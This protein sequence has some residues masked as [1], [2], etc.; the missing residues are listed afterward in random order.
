MVHRNP[1]T[2]RDD[3][4]DADTN[5]LLYAP[6]V[7]LE[8]PES[9]VKKN[10]KRELWRQGLL[11]VFYIASWYF[12][13][14]LLSLYNKWMFSPQHLNFHYPLFITSFHMIMQ[15]GMAAAVLYFIPRF[16]PP[17][18]SL[19]GY[20]DYVK[21]IGPCG[22]ATGLDIGL[23]NASLK[24]ISLA[25]YT[26]VKSSSL[27]WVLLFAFIFRLEKPRASLIGVIALITVGVVL[28]VVKETNFV[29]I[30][31]LL[32]LTASAL[33][34]FR[35]SLTQILLKKNPATS[36]PFS[37]I[38]FLAPVM[39]VTLIVSAVITEGISGFFTK[40][41]EIWHEKG[42]LTIGILLLPGFLAFLMTVAEF[43]LIQCTSVVTLSVAG[44]F[45]EMLTILVGHVVFRDSQFSALNISGL[46]V[47]ILGIA[48][49]NYLKIR[50]M[51][52]E[53]T[54]AERDKLRP[55]DEEHA[56]T[57]RR[58]VQEDDDDVVFGFGS[59]D[60]DSDEDHQQ[61]GR[62]SQGS[63]ASQEET[64]LLRST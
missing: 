19:F 11:N 53:A 52:K 33:G 12:F 5:G 26:M 23:S 13:S 39:F 47:T 21:K 64:R 1:S 49:Y 60:E 48:L 37:T 63:H 16:R 27:G 55:N 38:L 40:M 15:F 17:R 7:I 41:G 62:Q 14:L 56:D 61:I 25:F 42:I 45:K 43:S 3:D 58:K 50:R 6:E 2:D 20:G 30:G 32:V 10:V 54:Q 44:I 35:W 24:T 31:F 4:N 29:L 8:I 51:K 59:E 36:N 28:M 22:M 57:R 18:D 46:F 34:G 9:T